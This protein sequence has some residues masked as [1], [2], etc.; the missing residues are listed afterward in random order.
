MTGLLRHA[1]YVVFAMMLWALS[2]M[3][4]DDSPPP[5]FASRAQFV[6]M[7]PLAGFGTFPMTRPDGRKID[8][9]AFAGRVVLVNFW[10]S[11]CA[12][13]VAELPA[14]ARVQQEFSAEGLQVAAVSID[15]MS[16]AALGAFLHRVGANNLA[17]YFNPA[18][19]PGSPDIMP[20]RIGP[21]RL[22]ALPISYLI[23]RRGRVIGFFPGAAAWDSAEGK[24]FLRHYLKRRS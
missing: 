1:A 23:D 15:A 18:A 24:A 9:S 3:A 8:L 5:F 11:W 21:F 22:H 16:K 2:A 14:L 4:G 10:A 13:C 12:P 19:R 7:R 20:A 17:V 6:E